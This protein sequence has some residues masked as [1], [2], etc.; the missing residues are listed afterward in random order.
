MGKRKANDQD[1]Q[2]RIDQLS[3]DLQRYC[4][5]LQRTHKRLRD[6]EG[7]WLAAIAWI[8][9]LVKSGEEAEATEVEAQI[10]FL[11]REFRIVNYKAERFETLRNNTKRMLELSR[12]DATRESG[13][14]PVRD[15]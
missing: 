7:E 1:T 15:Y 2:T 4:E 14:L 9:R 3:N 6:L 8:R 12:S 5:S 13:R 11:C 10:E